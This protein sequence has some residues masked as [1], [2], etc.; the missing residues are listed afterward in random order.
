MRPRTARTLP[1]AILLAAATA[2]C[3]RKSTDRMARD[4]LGPVVAKRERATTGT[5]A[6]IL[7]AHGGWFAD[8]MPNAVPEVS[9][10]GADRLY[11]ENEVQKP[12]RQRPGKTPC[13]YPD[14]LKAEGI[15]GEVLAQFVVDRL[16]RY[17]QGTSKALRSSHDLFTRAT[18]NALPL[19]RFLPAEIGGCGVRQVVQQS[20]VFTLAG[21]A[22]DSKPYTDPPRFY[23]APSV[24]NCLMPRHHVAVATAPP[25]RM[26]LAA[27]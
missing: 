2:G 24:R 1:L 15:Q 23:A 13:R 11:F 21:G 22:G 27:V 14:L 6:A 19:L 25:R 26:L 18:E 4:G 9:P 16:G 17:E 3:E 5:C 8:P 12:A 7:H 10:R 20:S